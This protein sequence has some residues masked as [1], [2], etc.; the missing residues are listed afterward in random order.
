M[1]AARRC[2]TKLVMKSGGMRPEGCAGRLDEVAAPG[3]ATRKSQTRGNDN[4]GG[5]HED[6]TAMDLRPPGAV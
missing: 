2:P 4:D 6:K 5:R 3:A 1:A